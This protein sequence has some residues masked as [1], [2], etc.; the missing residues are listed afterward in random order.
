MEMA[1]VRRVEWQAY[2]REAVRFLHE[3][4]N[5]YQRDR[6]PLAAAGAAYYLQLSTIPLF[7]LLVSVA[8]FIITPEQ[9]KAMLT[10]LTGVLGPGVGRALRFEISSVFAHRGLITTISFFFGLW[11]G[12]QVF[13]I[14]ELALN[15]IWHVREERSFWVRSG[16]AVLMVLLT[17]VVAMLTIILGTVLRAIEQLHILMIN[18]EAMALPWPVIT[19]IDYLLPLALIT[20]FFAIAYR[21]LPACIIPWT[22]VMPGAVIGGVL[23]V[24]ALHFFSWYTA[25]FVNYSIIYGS[26]GG[27]ILLMLWFNYSAQIMLFGAEVSALLHKRHVEAGIA[28]QWNDEKAE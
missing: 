5:A 26:L 10:G 15:Q 1:Q 11:T 24:I 22:L 4:W 27:L 20:A 12:A 6:A 9:V 19:I 7:L 17:G 2:W 3:A 8:T 16:R 18:G 25:T 23:W 21:Y 14:L 13:V 28:E